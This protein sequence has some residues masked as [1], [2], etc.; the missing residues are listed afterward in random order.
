MLRKIV[1]ERCLLAAVAQNIKKIELL[2]VRLRRLLLDLRRPKT[3]IRQ[4]SGRDSHP[5]EKENFTL[6]K[7]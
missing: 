4:V 1:T 2:M 7:T 3:G 6:R 5:A